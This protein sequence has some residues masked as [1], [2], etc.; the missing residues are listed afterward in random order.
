MSRVSLQGESGLVIEDPLLVVGAERA[1]RAAGTGGD[2]AQL[3]P[4][5][6]QAERTQLAQG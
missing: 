5:F 4:R 1:F 6:W 2:P 3:T